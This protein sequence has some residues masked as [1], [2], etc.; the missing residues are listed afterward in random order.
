MP[1]YFP[2]SIKKRVCVYLLQRYLGQFFEEKLTLEQLSVDLYNGTGSVSKISL[3][4]QALN[5]LGEKQNWPLEFVDGYLD[6]LFVSVPWA[7]LLK[8]PSFIEVRG[9]KLTLQ[10]KQRNE[11][12]TSMFESMW[13]SMTNSMQLA[14]ECFKQEN[15][16]LSDSQPL[17][18][19]ERF[20]QTIDSILS[21]VRVKFIDTVIQIEHVPKE[22]QTGVALQINIQNMEYT[23]EAGNDPPVEEM[24]DPAIKEHKTYIVSSFTIKNFYLEGVTLSTVEYP[25]KARTFSRSVVQQS[26]IFEDSGNSDP[27]EA[28]LNDNHAD[29]KDKNSSASVGND[30]RH[31]ILF[32]K[33][34]GRQEIKV[35][36]KQSESINGPKVSMEINVGSFT[37]FLSPRQV[38][39]LL[40]FA[41]GLASPDSEDT[42]NVT[43]KQKCSEKPMNEMDFKIIEQEL[44][45]QL[46]PLAH[47]QSAGLPGTQGWSAAPDESDNDENFLPM[48]ISTAGVMCDSSTSF[49]S[50]SM[51]SSTNTSIAS[52]FTD[53][54]S[55]TKRRVNNIETDPSAE[56]SHFQIRLASF[57][58]VLLHED[59]L[60][61]PVGVDQILAPSSVQQ[62]QNTAESFF[63]NLGLFA[64]NGYGNKDF[65]N[66]KGTFEKACKFNHLRI[67]AAPIQIEGDEKTTLSTFS[68]SGK[69]IVAK[70]EFLECLY[71][72]DDVEYVP[73]LQFNCTESPSVNP[74]LKPCLK[75]IFKHVE[76]S[77][78]SGITRRKCLTK[79]D[80]SFLLDAC[81]V[82]VDITIVDRV[83]ALLNPQPI[84]ISKASKNLYA[85]NNTWIEPLVQTDSRLDLKVTSP[86]LTLKLRF[87]VPDFR[88]SHDMQKNPWWKRNV[89]PDY[90]TLKLTDSSVSSSWYSNQLYQQYIVECKEVDIQYTEFEMNSSIPIAKAGVSDKCGNSLPDD[91]YLVR[92]ILKIYPILKPEVELEQMQD[93][94]FDSMTQSVYGELGNQTG[95]HSPFSSKRTVHES[96]TPHN[97]PHQEK[98]I[99][100]LITP[101]DKQ[102]MANFID[103]TSQLVRIG[104]D[105]NLPCV[106]LQLVSKHIYE[107]IY[108]RINNDLLLWE[109]CAPKPKP[110]NFENINVDKFCYFTNI[111]HERYSMCRS[112]VQYESES[113]SDDEAD[114]NSN[115]FFSVCESRLRQ[116]RPVNFIVNESKAQSYFGLNLHIGQGLITLRTPVR[117][118]CLNVIPGQHGEFVFSVEDINVFIVSG[119]KG[120]NNLGYICVQAHDVQLHYCEMISTLSQNPPLKEV[121]SAVGNHLHTTIYKSEKGVLI[122]SSGRGG[123]REQVSVAIKIRANHET[124]HI[125]TIRVAL[126]INKST[127]R[128]RM[129]NEPNNWISQLI[130]FF[131]VFDYPIP[132]YQPKD[133]LTELHL[134][135]WDCAVDYRP[136]HLP[137]RSLLTVGTFS[138]SSNL[139]AQANTSTLRFIAEDCY[140][141]LSDKA[142]PRNGIPSSSSVDLKKDYVNVIDIGLFELSLKISDKKSGINPHIDLRASNN[143]VHIRTCADSGHALM[144]LITY[145]AS[146]GD[147]CSTN[148]NTNFTGSTNS[149]PRHQIDQELVSVEPQNISNLSKSQHEHVNDLLGEAMQESVCNE[150]KVMDD[151]ISGAN[152]FFFPD[153]GKQLGDLGKPPIQVTRELGDISNQSNKGSDTDEDFCFVGEDPGLG[154]L[155]KDGLPEIRWLM[156]DP[157]RLIDN[158]FSVPIGKTNL[159]MAPKHFPTPVMRYTLREMTIVWHMYGGNDFKI[160]DPSKKKVVGFSDIHTHGSVGFTNKDRGI[161]SFNEGTR[162]KQ[163]SDWKFSGGASRD[164]NILMELQLNKVRFQHEIYPEASVHSSRQVLLI[165]ELEIRDRL[166]TSAINKFLYQY[167]SQIRPKQ[168]HANMIVIK[169]VHLRSDPTLKTEECC[170][171][172]SLLPLRF[173]IDQDSLLFLIDFFSELSNAKSK[174]EG[175]STT[176]SK[177]STPTHQP[178]VMTVNVENENEIAEKAQKIVDENLLILLEENKRSEDDKQPKK[179]ASSSEVGLPIY[180][181]SVVFSPEVLIKID[182]HGKRVD[183]THGPLQ[184]LIMGLGQLDCSELKLK[185]ISNRHGILGVDKLLSYCLF[186][187]LNDIKKNQLPS[188]LG[189]VGPMHSLVQLFQGIRDLFWLPIEQYQKDGRIVRGL[190]RG[191]NSFTTSTAMAALELTS[192]IIHLI[193]M[194]AE[195]AYDMVSPGPSVKRR[196][197]AKGHKKR[198]SQ[199]QDIREGVANAYM[200]V[201]EVC[202]C[203]HLI[204]SHVHFNVNSRIFYLFT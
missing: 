140:L 114:I 38:H 193:Q 36:L 17:E 24:T 145:F 137:L 131:N 135:L 37:T 8:D 125:K 134:N 162:K 178:P 73:L 146:D 32:G 159:L 200:V 65:Q 158:H 142:P 34:S 13:S 83:N 144:Q 42:S 192:R 149:S 106:S 76:K 66:A 56:I 1:W 25:S 92:L 46:H 138:M 152:I 161:V 136:L 86:Q 10:P 189:G 165:S 129:Y 116:N 122:N 62:M 166:A 89:R 15:V 95:N 174:P 185:R 94:C 2:E 52:S 5:E 175:S 121:G 126:G 190:Q 19:I 14:E 91:F 72:K 39:V 85:E 180:F 113:E 187:W 118:T 169:A 176:Q 53:P 3:D 119:Y 105:L 155:P 127:L 199:P 23:D 63:R 184:G 41:N 81:L 26:Q 170:L 61:L 110:Q 48:K 79:T 49:G 128:H 40:E 179:I 154:L 71:E 88:P 101:G 69:L 12:A 6:E 148:E 57:A 31:V 16:N 195:T 201:K 74:I 50:N 203:L 124:H 18:V 177:H 186:E 11:S 22:S 9:L 99:E 173:N 77:C 109:P 172:I 156:E 107:L 51:E 21:R 191:A 90:L 58:M 78:R 59:I 167:T 194:T 202:F 30:E 117:D 160:V 93:T 108:N 60:A 123:D 55:R 151:A 64:I 102:E 198:Y 43:S 181:R 96:D 164:Q 20:A 157:V 147:L 97:K 27:L 130:D 112:G 182:Y 196:S 4:V 84:C 28:V 111:Q 171:K 80:I 87:P 103:K 139:S 141:F 132:G 98:E 82:E 133:V 104:I 197:K 70:L 54:S 44:Q 33:L 115:A 7:S 100:E 143:I 47:L 29:T 204:I 68:I 35:R 153:E 120:D 168:S 150:E 183:F 67:I 75:I 163:E 188:L 45:Q